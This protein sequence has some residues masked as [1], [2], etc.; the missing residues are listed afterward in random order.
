MS[1]MNCVRNLSRSKNFQRV[2][3]SILEKTYLVKEKREAEFLLY[4]AA[5]RYERFCKDYPD[6]VERVSQQHIATYLGIAPQSLSRIKK[7]RMN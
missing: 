3:T 5:E 1:L 6:L 7:V 4:N 2:Y